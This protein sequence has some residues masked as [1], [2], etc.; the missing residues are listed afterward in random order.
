MV[1]HVEKLLEKLGQMLKH[2]N[3]A[4][5]TG[6]LGNFLVSCLMYS[7]KKDYFIPQVPNMWC[8]HKEQEGMTEAPIPS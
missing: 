3:L 6:N 1:F 5:I 8:A 2:F 7:E 4:I